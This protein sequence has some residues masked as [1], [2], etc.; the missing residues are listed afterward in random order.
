MK[1]ILSLLLCLIIILSSIV[2]ASAAIT[3]TET[4]ISA[5]ESRL[6]WSVKLGTGYTNSPST[7]AVY[8]DYVLTMV[9]STLYKLS[10]EN[11]EIIKT[12][13]MCSAPSFSYTPVLVA[14]NKIFC[15]LEGGIVQAFDLNTMKSLW[16]YT[17][18]LGGQSLSPIIFDNGKVYTGFWNDEEVNANFVCLNAESG[19]LE[20]N[21]IQ[22][23][24]FYW[25]EPA[26]TGNF[27]VVGGDNG[28]DD[29]YS[30]SSLK[31][32]NKTTGK[33]IDSAEII[34]DQR[35]GI[36]S[37][38]GYLYLV[39][40]G[41]YLYKAKLDSYG[42][43]S[44]VKSVALSGSSTS[45]PTVYGG[46][47]YIGVQS[48]GFGGSMCVFDCDSL[49]IINTVTMNGYP[50]SEMLLTTA[51]DDVYIYSTYNAGPGGITVINGSTFASEQLFVPEEGSKGYCISPVSAADNGTLI[52]KN[53]S[54][55]IFA[56]GNVNSEETEE[57]SIF[58]LIIKLFVSV[59]NLF[60]SMLK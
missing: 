44:S 20:W 16:I 54:G 8:G 7:P 43:F 9:G 40:K 24:G 58:M 37:K 45:T 42:K 57:S 27:I 36:T 33:L 51:Y 38:D 39:T 35:S 15:P 59:I 47:I 29:V 11:G 49:G 2:S 3:Q 23:G 17:D 53:D 21:Y 56:V 25:A 30:V 12:A 55:T 4:P 13:E 6:K 5:D 18:S 32:F 14:N 26:V 52:Y 10:S 41:C 60:L 34:G 28:S 48:S 31:S 46:K 50:Q 19:K 22:K 1:K